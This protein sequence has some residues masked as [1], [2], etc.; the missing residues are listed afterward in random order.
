M[1]SSCSNYREI[2][3]KRGCSWVERSEGAGRG[4][5]GQQLLLLLPGCEIAPHKS[6]PGSA[7]AHPCTSIS[8]KERNRV[9][10]DETPG[11]IS[12]ATEELSPQQ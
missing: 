12:R 7:E 10:L 1:G 3:S 6:T 8:R 11:G 5:Y 2:C 9:N 4:G